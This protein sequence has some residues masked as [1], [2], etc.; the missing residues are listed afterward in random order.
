[1]QLDKSE[2]VGFWVRVGATLVDTLLVLVI[3]APF[4]VLVIDGSSAGPSLF[5]PEALSHPAELMQRLRA[6]SVGELVSQTDVVSG[7]W[8]F[9]IRWVFPPIAIILFWIYRQA[10]PGKMLFAARVVDAD[11]GNNLTVGQSIGRY[12]AYFVSSLPL[13]LGFLW[14][15]FDA[16]KQ[17]WHDKLAGTVV[18]KSHR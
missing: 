14:V 6:M 18:I 1:M 10:T 12:F 7:P 3:T 16:R 2:Y 15:A 4:V 11:T 17:G 9:L 13:C 8:G 5:G